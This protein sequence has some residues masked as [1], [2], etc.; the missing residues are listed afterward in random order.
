MDRRGLRGADQDDDPAGHLLHARARRR[1]GAQC[2][3]R[4]QGR[5]SGAGLLPHHVDGRPGHRTGGGQPDPP[6]RGPEPLG[7]GRRGREGAGRGRRLHDRVRH[8]DHPRLAVLLAHVRRRAADPA[9]GVAGR[10]RAPVHGPD[11][12]AD[13]GG[14]RLP[15][16]PGLPGAGDDHVGRSDRRLRRHGCGGRRDRL[17]GDQESR[18]PDAGV[19]HH[20]LRLRL[21]HP[22]HA[23]EDG[24]G[25]EHPQPVQVP[26]SRVP[27]DPLDLLL[28]VRT[29]AGDREDGARRR[30]PHHR[31]DRGPD[32]LLVQ[33]G[34][35]R[36]LP[37]D[38]LDLHRR[39][40]GRPVVHRR[41][42]LAA[43]VHDHRLQGRGRCH[44]RR[45]GHP[46][47]RPGVAPT[48]AA[49]R[50]RLH[51]GHRPVHVGGAC[52]DE[53]RRQLG[54][55]GAGRSLDRHLQPWAARPGAGR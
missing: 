11:G 34:R 44:R 15:A 48:G 41:A 50:R 9:G 18:D 35:H 40:P 51:R 23:A 30:G 47:R 5:R 55:H 4:R 37:D 13:P 20:L 10:F 31:R 3:E 28:G 21:R 19:L 33:P 52:P 1:L 6:R 54:G 26:R 36:D 2:R 32:G 53:L 45:S 16:A 12:R 38:G 8:R 42:D 7:R 46:R 43:A 25:R 17:G 29:A 14:H 39:G 27:A 24:H 49:G 22:R